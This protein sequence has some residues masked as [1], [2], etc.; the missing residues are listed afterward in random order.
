MIPSVASYRWYKSRD[1]IEEATRQASQIKTLYTTLVANM[2]LR[3][4]HLAFSA[5]ATNVVDVIV[6]NC[7]V[8]VINPATGKPDK[9]YLVTVRVRK[10]DFVTLD[11][12]QVQPVLCLKRLRALV[13]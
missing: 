5:D 11:L 10:D 7:F 9:P 3:T 12:S 1:E 6:L 2:T 8:D 4:L 13:S